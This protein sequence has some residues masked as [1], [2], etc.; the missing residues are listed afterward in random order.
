MAAHTRPAH[1]VK[2]GRVLAQRGLSGLWAP[3]PNQETGIDT[4]DKVKMDALMSTT[5]REGIRACTCI[6]R[7]LVLVQL[8][9]IRA[10]LPSS[11]HCDEN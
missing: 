10:L 3:T 8:S 11:I 5:G 9:P 2:P 4:I 6:Q 7:S 1:R